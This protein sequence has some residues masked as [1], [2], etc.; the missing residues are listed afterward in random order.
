MMVG[1]FG[2]DLACA[3]GAGSVGVLM[4]HRANEAFI[5][6]ADLVLERI[7]DLVIPLRDGFEVQRV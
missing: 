6:Q 5:P 7:E 4:R 2:D 1:D 3:K